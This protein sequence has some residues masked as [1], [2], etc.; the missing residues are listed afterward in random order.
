MRRTL[1]TIFR[2]PKQ[3][4]TLLILLPLIGLLTA[5]LLPR[6][7]ES[8]A[9]LW[10]LR[11]YDSNNQASSANDP[12]ATPAH[13]QATALAQLLQTRTFALTVAHETSLASTLTLDANTANN[14]QLLDDALFRAISQGV[15]VTDSGNNLFVV[16]YKNQDPKVAQQVVAAVVQQYAL[17]AERIALNL[18]Q[19]QLKDYQAQL[20]KTRNDLSAAQAAQSE[21]IAAHPELQGQ[22]QTDPQYTL[23]H[24]RTVQ[25]QAQ[26]QDIQTTIDTIY[27]DIAQQDSTNS[28]FEVL[29]TPVIAVQPVSRLGL[30][31]IAGG[32][33]SG[34]AL[35][36]CSLYIIILVRR[37]RAVYSPLDVQN[38][39]ALPVVAQLPHLTPTTVA[40]L[41]DKAEH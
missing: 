24:A 16:D 38:T 34:L 28:F 19:Q 23:L 30:F 13:T 3:L 12:S 27:R 41:I 20:A 26:L 18:G 9:R 32:I 29:D 33:G 22:L 39:L 14:P 36:A 15:Q 17:Q 5:L 8:T 6:S 2:R 40:A 37:D 35:L 1:E 4:L 10:A 31:L 11:N 21:Y 7:Y 25:A